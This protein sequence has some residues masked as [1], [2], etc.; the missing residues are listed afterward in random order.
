M[1]RSEPDAI[2]RCDRRTLPAAAC[3]M[4]FRC[5]TVPEAAA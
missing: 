1:D 2:L 3:G 5:G 4:V